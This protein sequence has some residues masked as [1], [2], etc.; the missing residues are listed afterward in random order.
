MNQLKWRQQ[1]I[2]VV[3]G[4][5]A[6]SLLIGGILFQQRLHS[7]KQ[8]LPISTVSQHRSLSGL[9]QELNE[10]AVNFETANVAPSPDRF[11]ALSI[12]IDITLTLSE[13]FFDSI[14]TT[15]HA[16]LI[17]FIE[18]DLSEILT[19]IDTLIERREKFVQHRAAAV[20]LRLQGAIEA[21]QSIYLE[22]NQQAFT[23]LSLQAG[24]IEKL[25]L[26][27]TLT[28][29]LLAL[30][31]MSIA[32]LLYLHFRSA[33]MLS[34]ARERV[35]ILSSAIEQS[36]VSV[37]I[38]D[39]L[40]R[41]E[42]INPRF[43]EVSGYS[44]EEV[45]AQDEDIISFGQSSSEFFARNK[46]GILS[47]Q[48]WHG[49]LKNRKKN[50]SELW[51]SVSVSPLYDSAGNVKHFIA[52][53]EDITD[54]KAT[55][56]A[57]Q[58]AMERAE[59]AT[60]A[61]TD[62]L[63]NMS[64][65]IRTPMNAVLG[66]AELLERRISDP[67][68]KDYLNAITSGGKT[69]LQIINDILDISKIEAGK[70]TLNYDSF[71]LYGL[72]DELKK[73]F[74]V[75]LQH[76]RLDFSVSVDVDVPKF[77]YADEVRLR[78][79]LFNLVGNA[80]K[81]TSQGGVKIH[82]SAISVAGCEETHRDLAITIEDSG[83][84][85]ASDQL[86]V[87]FSA[88]EQQRG[89][90]TASYGGTGLGLSIC[91]K[92]VAMMDGNISVSSEI[93]KGSIFRIFLP[94]IKICA[95]VEPMLAASQPVDSSYH[96]SPG[97]ILV[98]DDVPT[99]RA[100]I[101]EYLRDTGLKVY[102]VNHGQEVLEALDQRSFDLV[103]LD[104]RMP[105]MDGIICIQHIRRHAQW[106]HLPVIVLTA[107]AMREQLEEMMQYDFNAYL[108]KPVSRFDIL[109]SIA[110][111][112][113][114]TVE[115][116]PQEGELNSLKQDGPIIELPSLLLRLRNLQEQWAEIKDR[117]DFQLIE[118]FAS[119]LLQLAQDHQAERLHDYADKLSA[120]VAAFDIEAVAALM[121][122][123]PEL[124]RQIQGRV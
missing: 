94:R 29:M 60:Q 68:E 9:I 98:A 56:K 49:E 112:L 77:F 14:N 70:M 42:Y 36:P 106:Q 78:Q 82:V 121:N 6:V 105:V 50:G 25:G 57:L 79:I 66:F 53:K 83:I 15:Q 101:K 113:P 54:K 84:G 10:L 28:G 96:F 44:S 21:L 41:I 48:V 5:L 108:R 88:F 73:L 32:L 89:Q 62:F 59:Q 26:T 97:N 51:E 24:Q 92:L 76:K 12:S 87:I 43:S 11:D 72:L 75:T 124:V 39:P 47:Q 45:L 16:G 117:G 19:E 122:S 99:N 91:Q 38:T 18:Q 46:D 86:E 35:S 81:F 58:E 104:L 64:H 118:D 23:S 1:I 67:V 37:V 33:R 85:I 40:G 120:G 95:E 20:L 7:I 80:I 74:S 102:E 123:Y 119:Q 61:K 116:N 2:F 115:K 65:E 114:C 63:A 55:E 93:D 8:N 103:F 27:V 34:E 22:A 4:L 71:N 109:R 31:I 110:D 30:T 100:L 3:L 107:S 52:M 90:Q 13:A 111:Y 17:G 69:L